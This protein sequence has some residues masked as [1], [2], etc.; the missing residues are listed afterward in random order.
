MPTNYKPTWHLKGKPYPVQ[1]EAMKRSRNRDRY[2]Y[3][4]EMGLGKTPL[5]INDY[6][7]NFFDQIDTVFIVC[8][9]SFKKDWTLAPA[10][11]GVPSITTS[12]W[13]DQD[14]RAGSPG[15]P[16]FNVFNFEAVRSSGYDKIRPIMDS[17]PCLLVVDESTF[18]KN[19]KSHTSKSILDLSKR[20]AAVRLLNGTPMVQNVMDLFPQLKCLGELDRVNPYVFKNR[21]AVT[22]GFMGKQIIGVKNEAELQE[23]QT[24]CSFRALKSDWWEDCPEKTMVPLHLEMTKTQAKHYAEMM[25]DFYTI[26][27]RD[28]FSANLVLTQLDKCRQIASGMIMD[29]DKFRL[30]EPMHTNPKVQAV[31]DLMESGTGKMIVV[32]FYRGMGLELY[33]YYKKRGFNPAYIRG[34][35]KPEAVI[36]EKHKFNN[37]STCRILVAQIGATSMAHTL[38]GQAG[39][40]RCYRMFFHDGTFSLRDRLQIEDRIHRGEQDRGCLYYDPIMSPID[41]AQLDALQKKTDVARAVVDAVRTLRDGR[42]SR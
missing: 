4:M 20:A 24:R 41:K 26:V 13:P 18:I 8:P 35:M 22:G 12:L 42:S 31:L 23:I 14:P 5:V 16:H 27:G 29:G 17:R 21:Y 38:V 1:M 34:Q 39:N 10:D 11:W 3:F 40:D 28:E 37:D 32:H 36:C 9:Q 7:E 25:E 30:I 2:A 15:R 6:I 19:F 33:D